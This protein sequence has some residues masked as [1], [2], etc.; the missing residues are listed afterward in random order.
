MKKHITNR[1]RSIW[2]SYKEIK[3]AGGWACLVFA[4]SGIYRFCKYRVGFGHSLSSKLGKLRS[5]L[6]VAADTIH[7]EWRQPLSI[8]GEKAQLIYTGYLHDW[9]VSDG[10]TPLSLKSTYAQWDPDFHFTHLETSQ[11]DPNS[12]GTDDPRC[13]SSTDTSFCNNCGYLQSNDVSRNECRCFP[14]L[15]GGCKTSMAVQVFRTP[16]G[17]NNGLIARCVSVLLP[18]CYTLKP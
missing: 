7:P 13:T 12:W 16:S 10:G 1:S 6:E 4:G 18:C 5:S 3:D 15:Y 11:L 17:N 14:E 9:V 2:R 8:I